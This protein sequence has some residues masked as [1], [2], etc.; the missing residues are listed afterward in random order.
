MAITF[1]GHHDCPD[2]IKPKLLETIENRIKQGTLQFY[3]GNH[4]NFDA[5]VLSCLRILKQKYPGIRYAVILAYLSGNSKAYLP[6]E[7]LFPGGIESVQKRFAI[8]Y[9]NRWMLDHTNTVIAYVSR[10]Y[11]GASKYLERAKRSGKTIVNLADF[12]EV[13]VDYLL[14]RT[15]RDLSTSAEKKQAIDDLKTLLDDLKST[16]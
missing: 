2:S 3:V 16:L 10:S 4:G 1:F 14:G 11:G 13:S 9:C 7:T 12:F 5:M 15:E 8:D 6:G